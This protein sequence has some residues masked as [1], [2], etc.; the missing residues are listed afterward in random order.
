MNQP[1]QIIR[2]DDFLG[3]C[4]YRSLN[5]LLH[6]LGSGV[7]LHDTQF[8]LV[9]AVLSGFTGTLLWPADEALLIISSFNVGFICA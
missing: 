5:D 2:V 6:V 3:S 4:V 7:E 8:V 1:G 9:I